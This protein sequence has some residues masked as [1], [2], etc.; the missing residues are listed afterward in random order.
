MSVHCVEAECEQNLM[1]RAY[2]CNL[3]PNV[4]KVEFM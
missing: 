2:E 3:F 4:N 1:H